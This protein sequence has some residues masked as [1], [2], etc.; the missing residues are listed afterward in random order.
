MKF[1]IGCER[2]N[3]TILFSDILPDV[4]D[5]LNAG[6]SFFIENIRDKW[7]SY[8]GKI[9]SA[10]SNPDRMFRKI[11][12]VKADHSAYANELSLHSGNILNKLKN[13]FGPHLITAVRFEVVKKSRYRK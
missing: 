3:R 10:H 13:D 7:E 5:E 4:I 2:N 6:D 8:V 12:F 9:L 1:R 11:L